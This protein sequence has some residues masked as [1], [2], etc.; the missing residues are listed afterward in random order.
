MNYWFGGIEF[1][2]G[3]A[4]P[5]TLEDGRGAIYTWV[6]DE[7]ILE[8]NLLYFHPGK[9]RGNHFHPEFTEYF[10]VA[11]GVV[12]LF[13]REPKSNKIINRLCGE[14]TV[15]RSAPRVPHTILAITEA[16]CISLITKPWDTCDVPIVYEP[17]ASSPDSNF[18]ESK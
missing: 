13:T 15:F 9:S 17:L 18:F 3:D 4:N 10:M 7:P 14:G 8:F 5:I 12:A 2:L 11:Q 1:L 16:K 6:P